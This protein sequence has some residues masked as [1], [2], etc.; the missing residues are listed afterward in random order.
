[1]DAFV[2]VILCGLLCVAALAY[3][4]PP[5]SLGACVLLLIGTLC[6]R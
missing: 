1:M 6:A 5:F 4:P 3:I 2:G